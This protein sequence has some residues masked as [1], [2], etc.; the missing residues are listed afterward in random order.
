MNWLDAFTPDLYVARVE[1]ITPELLHKHGL[2]GLLLDL[3]NTLLDNYAQHFE[4]H[5]LE[6]AN[7]VRAQ[8]IEL[9]I[10]TNAPPERTC[11][12][13]QALGVPGIPRARKP[14]I[15]GLLAGLK[16]LG[17]RP[18]QAAMVGDQIF[19]DVWAG[20][21]AGLFTIL[22]MPTSPHESWLTRWKRPLERRVLA[23]LAGRG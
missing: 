20:N 9:C 7:K 13:A 8:G 22:V 19:T 16:R 5:I 2:R 3:D 4:S 12:L 15:S 23:R 11:T 18:D 21:R 14:L 10:V 1:V 17:L 6:W